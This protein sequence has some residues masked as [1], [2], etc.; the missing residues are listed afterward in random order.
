MTTHPVRTYAV[1][2]VSDRAFQGR[3]AD[4]SGPVVTE[5]LTELLG[6]QPVAMRVVPDDEATIRDTLIELCD[7]SKCAL[8]VTTGGTGL[9]PRDVTPEATRAVISREIPGLAEAMRTEGMKKT[10]TACLSRGLC[11]QR[12]KSLIINLSGSPTAVREQL[13]VLLPILPHAL[14]VANDVVTDCKVTDCK[15]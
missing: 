12:G 7:R 2:T 15:S 8:V 6:N 13:S 1:L 14:D 5:M 10:P 4:A 3:R 11:G 9:A